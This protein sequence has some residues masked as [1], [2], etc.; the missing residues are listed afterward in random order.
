MATPRFDLIDI[1]R[2]LQRKRK[3]ILIVAALCGITAAIFYL[4]SK[5]Y[6]EAKVEFFVSN[7]L[8]SD[9]NN[10]FR[11]QES[12]FVDYFTNE[13][14]MDRVLAIANSGKVISLVREKQNLAAAYKLDMSKPEDRAAFDET[15]RKHYEV[16]RADFQN[17]ELSFSNPDPQLAANVANEAVKATEEVYREYFNSIKRNIYNSIQA[18]AIETDSAIASLTDTLSKLR[19][20]YQIYDIISPSRQGMMNG[21]MKS[22]GA[23]TFGRGVEEIQNVES[24]KDQLV[25]DRAE[26]TSLLNEFSTG[27]RAGEMSLVNVITKAE[28]PVNP[29][30]LGFLLTTIAGILLGL[31]FASVCVLLS[32]YYH[33]LNTYQ[34]EA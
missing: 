27:V 5:K 19:D 30:G 8:Y 18:K 9:R 4:V 16:K 33:L 23:T 12:R 6:Y 26:Y 13:D 31:F 11:N 25:K 2:S 1:I 28:P 34:R 17:M 21:A 15:F 14:D 20:R 3:I 24:I 7:P 32:A 29:K 10:L 22:N